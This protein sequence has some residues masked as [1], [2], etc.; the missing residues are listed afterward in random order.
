MQNFLKKPFKTKDIHNI[1][2]EA[3]L[4]KKKTK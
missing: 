2:L 3:I 4:G 1:N